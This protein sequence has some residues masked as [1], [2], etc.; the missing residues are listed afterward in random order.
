MKKD[1]ILVL[2]QGTTN[3]KAFVFD[4]R[5]DV[6]AVTRQEAPQ[7]FPRPGW[8][9]QDP[10]LLVKA[11]IKIGREA[12]A[13]ADSQGFKIRAM[14]VTNQTEST[15]L[16]ERE[17][18]TPIYNIITWQCQRTAEICKQLDCRNLKELIHVRTG[19]PLD[20]A[21][22]AWGLAIPLVLITVFELLMFALRKLLGIGRRPN[23]LTDEPLHPL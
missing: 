20:T 23:D 21:S 11:M 15:V 14:G 1:C 13:R 2:D 17:T 12:A 22:I 7:I 18:G 4:T 19:L 5:G 8:V 9:E 16:W 3:L 6:V 10:I